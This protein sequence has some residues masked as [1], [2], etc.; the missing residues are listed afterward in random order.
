MKIAK[1]ALAFALFSIWT[2]LPM[3]MALLWSL[4][5]PERPWS[6]PHLFPP[7]L[8]LFHWKHAFKYTNILGA[9]ATSFTLAASSTLI[10][11]IL[12]LPTSFALARRNPRGKGAMMMLALLPIMMP[13]MT[14][15]IFFGRLLG[16]VE[17]L[18]G[19]WGVLLGH[20]FLGLPYMIR[21]LTVSF[22]SV[23]QDIVDAADDL[24]AGPWV[25]MREIYFPMIL[26]GLM[27]GSLFTFISSLEEFNLAYVVGAP[28]IETI[29]TILFSYLGY[30]FV[31]TSSSVV[32]II[33]VLPNLIILFVFERYFKAEYLSAGFGK[34]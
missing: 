28:R 11:F 3:L 16:P 31:R 10:A 30:H 8:S 34:A 22:E 14:F 9:I 33:L 21:I 18:R 1:P 5:D 6:Y 13:G 25:K 2:G 20:V 24:G 29:T 26:P 27:A 19:Y 15:A 23:P 4:V 17:F 12:A 7:G 32:S